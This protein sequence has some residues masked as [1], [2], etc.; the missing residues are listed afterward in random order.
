[1]P[2]P[3]P[4]KLPMP[5]PHPT[6]PPPTDVSAIPDVVPRAEPRSAK[7]NPPFYDVLGKRGVRLKEI[8]S[9][10][11]EELERLLDRKVHLFLHVKV[12]EKWEE[13]RGLYREIGLDWVD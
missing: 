3:Q 9:R 12:A 1:M 6:L 5:S 4:P 10:S 13:D 8:G 7:G 2:A 11:R